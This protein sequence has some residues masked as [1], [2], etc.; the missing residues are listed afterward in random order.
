MIPTAELHTRLQ[1]LIASVVHHGRTE[2]LATVSDI[3][4]VRLE[5]IA[6]GADMTMTEFIV[7]DNL[8]YPQ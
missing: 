3:A 4:V 2:W 7:L 8:R 1:R 5:Q 6:A